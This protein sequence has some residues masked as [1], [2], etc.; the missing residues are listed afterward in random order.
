[1]DFTPGNR[2]QKVIVDLDKRSF[3][4]KVETKVG[5]DWDQERMQERK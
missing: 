1:M 5:S 4:R 2:N 3:N